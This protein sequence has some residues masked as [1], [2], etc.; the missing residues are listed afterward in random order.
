M[1]RTTVLIDNLKQ[2]LRIRRPSGAGMARRL[3]IERLKQKQAL[4][5][6]RRNFAAVARGLEMRRIEAL[7]DSAP[8]VDEVEPEQVRSESRSH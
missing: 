5:I 2:A 4:R 1:G 8:V 3:V 7:A 6:R